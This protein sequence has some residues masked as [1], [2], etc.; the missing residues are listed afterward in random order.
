MEDREIDDLHVDLLRDADHMAA[1]T[2][3]LHL[4]EQVVILDGLTGTGKTM[5][6]PLLSSLERMQNARFEYML[7]YLCI[8]ASSGKLTSDAAHSLLN[9]LADNKCY[10]GMISR[11]VNF[12]P[13][14]LSSVFN[15]SKPLKYVRQLFMPDGEVAAK[16][17]QQERP[18]LLFVTHQ[19]LTCMETAIDAF[20][21]RLR[22]IQMVRHPLYL[23]DHWDSYLGLFGTSPRDL[24][25]WLDHEGKS[26]P[27]FAKGWEDR[28]A[29]ASQFDNVIHS[30]SA[31]MNPV[32]DRAGREDSRGTIAFVPFERFVLSPAPFLA[33]IERLL[34]TSATPATAK[35]MR[36]QKLPRLS[37]NDG[38]QKSIYKR[39]RAQR[40]NKTVTHA[41][42]YDRLLEHA[43]RSSSDAAFAVLTECMHQYE[44]TF[45][46]WF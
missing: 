39:Y 6:S 31:L 2:R 41:Q 5:F 32:F 24:T 4:S 1:F 34:G 42:D 15:S 3:P 38:P 11:E 45:G 17:L 16:R 36:S 33:D 27:W 43:R 20:G 30:I 21:A 26:L 12:R 14:D 44:R 19:L 23:L 37:I 35:V 18:I 25:V 9:L 28:Y 40:Y 29:T 8:A 22:V 10:D 46:L 7:E 13:G